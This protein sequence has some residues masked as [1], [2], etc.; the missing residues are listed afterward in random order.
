MK[1]FFLYSVS[2]ASRACG[3]VTVILSLCMAAGIAAQMVCALDQRLWMLSCVGG[4]AHDLD[5]TRWILAIEHCLQHPLFG[6]Q[7]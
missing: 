4:L 7:R 5:L 6:T 3:S 2:S 1:G